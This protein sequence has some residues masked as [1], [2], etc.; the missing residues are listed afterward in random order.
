MVG[1]R[2]PLAMQPLTG[3]PFSFDPG[4]RCL[5]LG[6]TGGE[7][8]LAVY[9]KLHGPAD[10]A[11]WLR[12]HVGAE[13]A[14][15]DDHDL[16]AAKRLR[17]AIW[18]CA[19]ARAAREAL[20]AAA[21]DEINR[22]AAH[23]PLVP[24]IDARHARALAVPVSAGQVLSTLARDAVD[25]FTGP[26]AGRIRRCAG[27]NCPLVFVDMSRPGRR[28]WCAMERCGNRAKASAF[29]NRHRHGGPPS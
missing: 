26:M 16:A 17:T 28:R 10:L 12:D 22:A 15:V 8:E 1:H 6:Y 3:A 29:R 9:E 18:R 25:L 23:P 19:D 14:Q 4:A 13:V 21:V 11:A 27:T 5:E 2:Q 20:P 24:R 7:G